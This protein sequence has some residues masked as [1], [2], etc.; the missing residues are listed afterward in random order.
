VCGGGAIS[1]HGWVAILLE[2]FGERRR[3]GQA[4]REMEGPVEWGQWLREVVFLFSEEAASFAARAG[5]ENREG[6]DF[7][8]I[9]FSSTFFEK[10]ICQFFFDFF[11]SHKFDCHN[12]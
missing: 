11:K 12:L 10:W 7:F 5:G 9:L 1:A 8:P 2:A 4:A 6:G 3:W